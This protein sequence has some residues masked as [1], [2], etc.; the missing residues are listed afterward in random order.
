MAGKEKVV[1]MSLCRDIASGVWHIDHIELR[2]GPV[3]NNTRFSEAITIDE[4]LNQDMRSLLKQFLPISL[5]QK[6]ISLI[7]PF[8]L[9]P[10]TH[11]D[12]VRVSLQSARNGVQRAI[13]WFQKVSGRVFGL[14]S[15]SFHPDALGHVPASADTQPAL[16]AKSDSA[17]W[18]QNGCNLQPEG[19]RTSQSA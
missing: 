16:G 5:S 15:R 8:R 12:G 7:G 13:V 3:R 4:A 2:F 10:Q 6:I 19:R 9:G 14:F 18:L 1:A 17:T 11:A